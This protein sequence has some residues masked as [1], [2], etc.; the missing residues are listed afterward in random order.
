M[1]VV[2]YIS[3][4]IY[5]DNDPFPDIAEFAKSN[6][7]NPNKVNKAIDLL[8]NDGILNRDDVKNN[9]TFSAQ[10][11]E[12]AKNILA[13]HFHKTLN[14]TLHQMK[15]CGFTEDEI[16]KMMDNLGK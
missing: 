8:I 6:I 3:H 9:I 15:Q 4:G 13:S 14:E 1:N 11:T 2:F 16:R 12:N 7:L 10:A 5:K